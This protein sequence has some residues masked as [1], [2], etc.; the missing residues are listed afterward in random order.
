M[1]YNL[2]RPSYALA[3]TG[4]RRAQGS[5]EEVEPTYTQSL[6]P[7]TDLFIK[8]LDKLWF[9][10]ISGTE[11]SAMTD[12]GW[13]DG[14]IY[15]TYFLPSD[16]ESSISEAHSR[17]SFR[18]WCSCRGVEDWKKY[19]SLCIPVHP[20]VICARNPVL[21]ELINISID[22]AM[23]ESYTSTEGPAALGCCGRCSS[24]ALAV[25]LD[26]VISLDCK[27]EKLI[28]A[29]CILR[30][31]YS[32][33]ISI[34]MLIKIA[35]S[36]ST[37]DII[38]SES[39]DSEGL[40]SDFRNSYIDMLLDVLDI[41]YRLSVKLCVEE[42]QLH[43]DCIIGSLLRVQ[44]F[45]KIMEIAVKYD[46][47]QLLDQCT[48]F[49]ATNFENIYSSAVLSCD[50]DSIAESEKYRLRACRYFLTA[51]QS[52]DN[53][54]LL[55]A[56]VCINVVNI[57]DSKWDKTEI[58]RDRNALSLEIWW[59][60]LKDVCSLF[61]P[62]LNADTKTG[63]DDAQVPEKAG[64]GLELL[65]C[66]EITGRGDDNSSSDLL[67]YAMEIVDNFVNAS[68][69]GTEEI[70][71]ESE[72]STGDYSIESFQ[73]SNDATDESDTARVSSFSAS[74][75]IRA[76]SL[77][78]AERAPRG[79]GSGTENMA[80][81]P[82]MNGPNEKFGPNA[83]IVSVPSVFGHSSVLV[84]NDF[85]LN[86]GGRNNHALFGND[87]LLAFYPSHCKWKYV[88]TFG[89]VP[90]MLNNAV[91]LPLESENTRHVL[92]IDDKYG[93]WSFSVLDC[94]YM[95]WRS[96]K[97]NK[98]EDATLCRRHRATIAAVPPHSC[99]YAESTSSRQWSYAVIWGGYSFDT[100]QSRDDV[101]VV[102]VRVRCDVD[103]GAQSKEINEAVDALPLVEESKEDIVGDS[104]GG[105]FSESD[106]TPLPLL[107]VKSSCADMKLHQIGR[108]ADAMVT[109]GIVELTCIQPLVTGN[110]PPPRWGSSSALMHAPSGVRMI[111]HG[112]V[113]QIEGMI[114]DDVFSLRCG[115]PVSMQWDIT[116]ITG[117][118]PGIR[119][120]HSMSNSSTGS[121][122]V[123]GG[124]VLSASH[125]RFR[126]A[127]DNNIYCLEYVSS[128]FN[129]IC[130][131][132]SSI[133][134]VHS[135]PC[136][137][138]LKHTAVLWQKSLTVEQV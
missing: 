23:K 97:I 46:R 9:R 71:S 12:D 91:A 41:A 70:T 62:S 33:I 49:L 36:S 38:M 31:L 108:I 53:K 19:Y 54:M 5:D 13:R 22:G 32:G 60:I 90:P 125:W 8:S 7:P 120:G 40:P 34:D 121:I 74:S 28:F 15:L 101:C 88:Q 66:P 119:Y 56:N 86:F 63:H 68:G 104:G 114:S 132:W 78:A 6:L 124:C 14:V 100:Q 110:L 4:A 135:A 18:I 50:E 136:A 96:V 83:I 42:M 128:D 1:M 131:R 138:R 47:N 123:Y 126:E 11:H 117:M 113:G 20:A 29:N 105:L 69:G 81:S 26:C 16:I 118:G 82:E 59:K 3:A 72:S 106:E 95:M 30:Y 134:P 58:V 21:S 79:Y 122:L 51:V 115:N 73:N 84:F 93:K 99:G 57:V 45:Q 61:E 102:K 44:T 52:I 116:H 94:L 133:T 76:T 75:V 43:L 129:S 80:L 24:Q 85:V 103:E 35:T 2:V 39:L 48:R 89:N 92:F 65:D 27:I 25:S 130:L 107:N 17:T 67:G 111:I 37:L 55:L 112:G 64:T 10:C 109:S 137:L 87:L 127:D 98:D 77:S